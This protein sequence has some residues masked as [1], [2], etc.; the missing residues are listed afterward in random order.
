MMPNREIIRFIITIIRMYYQKNISNSMMKW[1]NKSRKHW[2]CNNNNSSGHNNSRIEVRKSLMENIG[3]KNRKIKDFMG[4]VNIKDNNSII[5]V[6]TTK[7]KWA[8]N[9]NLFNKITQKENKMEQ[10]IMLIFRSNQKNSDS[11]SMIHN[12][13]WWHSI[14]SISFITHYLR[15]RCS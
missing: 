2:Y 14:L 6:I 8:M 12:S 10:K 9:I 1:L 15:I 13:N 7:N 11:M 3:T 5:T 4:M